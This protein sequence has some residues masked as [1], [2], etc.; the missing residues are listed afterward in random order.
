[1]KINFDRLINDLDGKPVKERATDEKGKRI[2][3]KEVSLKRVCINALVLQTDEK[4]DG[5]EQV[6]RFDLAT[7][8]NAGGEINL[9]T[10]EISKIKTLVSKIYGV[11]VVG[12]AFDLLENREEE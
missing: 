4:I 1:M 10:D 6:T 5:P 7:K 2:P 3:D 8:I 11:I 9:E 12:R